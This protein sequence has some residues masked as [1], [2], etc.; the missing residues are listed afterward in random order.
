MNI[1]RIITVLAALLPLAAGATTLVIPASGTGPGANDSHWQTELTLH[2]TSAS[3]IAAT[4]TFHDISGAAGTS[5]ITVA[6]RATVSVADIVATSFGRTAATGAIDVT[7]DSAFARK[8]TVSS[9]T[10]N[11]SAAGEFGQDIPSVDL[12]SVPA[13]GSVVV[14]S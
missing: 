14:L 3:A 10:F 2:N 5:T 1:T 9:R 7:F 11:K 8:L 13:A 6:P 4:L 12:S